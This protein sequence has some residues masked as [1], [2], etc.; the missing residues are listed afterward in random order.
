MKT[1]GSLKNLSLGLLLGGLFFA[2]GLAQTSG[3]TGQP[4]APAAAATTNTDKA[5][6]TS[7]GGGGGKDE[8]ALTVSAADLAKYGFGGGVAL[9]VMS[10]PGIENA[11]V[12]AN[13]IIRVDEASKARAGAILEY[14]FYWSDRRKTRLEKS[15][16]AKFMGAGFTNGDVVAGTAR[17]DLVHGPAFAV[18]FGGDVIR[19]VGLGYQFSL[20]DYTLAKDADKKVI[21]TVGTP[22]NLGFFCMVE[23]SV[24][25]LAE[26]QKAN[27]AL[28]TG[29]SLRFKKEA[30]VGGAVVLS[31]S[32]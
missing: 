2:H 30:H 24:K 28:P 32:F 20:R 15:E 31:Y 1:T 22:F 19:S 29:D 21:K 9:I 17:W 11:S 25:V 14:H 3:A 10:K 23:P 5:P 8:N 26:G 13:G 18:E 12:D 27:V 6:D 4:A 7:S 16:G